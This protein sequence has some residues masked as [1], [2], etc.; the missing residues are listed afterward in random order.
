MSNTKKYFRNISKSIRQFRLTEC[1][2]HLLSQIPPFAVLIICLF[3][4]A[5][6]ILKMKEVNSDEEK[7]RFEKIV[8]TFTSTTQTRFEIY[9]HALIATKGFINSRDNITPQEFKN[10][11]AD[12]KLQQNYPGILGIG[13]SQDINQSKFKEHRARFN[14]IYRY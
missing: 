6:A 13:L 14:K 7:T 3:V 2:E 9:T 8:K 1:T 12:L 4:T 11:V 10:F 5:A